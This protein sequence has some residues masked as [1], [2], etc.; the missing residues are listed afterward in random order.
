MYAVCVRKQPGFANCLLSIRGTIAGAVY[1]AA[2]A[3][4]VGAAFNFMFSPAFLRF[5]LAAPLLPSARINAAA[6]PSLPMQ[7]RCL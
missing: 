3:A 6:L 1:G 5:I 2:V 4:L 7:A